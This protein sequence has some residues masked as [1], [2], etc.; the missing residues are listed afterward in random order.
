MLPGPWWLLELNMAPS[1]LQALVE[2]LWQQQKIL[3][4]FA[5]FS[6]KIQIPGFHP[7]Q[8]VTAPG[9]SN[10]RHLCVTCPQPVSPQL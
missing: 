10:S 8:V 3:E 1:S 2:G 4:T 9:V 7:V 5:F 6:L